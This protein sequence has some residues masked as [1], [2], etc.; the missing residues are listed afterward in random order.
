MEPRDNSRSEQGRS[1]GDE[2][3]LDL[4]FGSNM[5]DT[6]DERNKEI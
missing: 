4:C 1:I 5:L 2:E 6:G 3:M